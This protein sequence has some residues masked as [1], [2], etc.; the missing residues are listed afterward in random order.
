MITYVIGAYDI[1]AVFSAETASNKLN[2]KPQHARRGVQDARRVQALFLVLGLAVKRQQIK[3]MHLCT[4]VT[5]M[6]LGA[7]LFRHFCN[8]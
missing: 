2:H 5:E 1:G 8:A 6:G 4:N 3:V 7:T